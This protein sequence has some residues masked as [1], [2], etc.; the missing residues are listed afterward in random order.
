[1]PGLVHVLAP[2][3]V[4][5]A[6]RTDR[7]TAWPA[8]TP[9]VRRAL[10]EIEAAI[11]PLRVTVDLRCCASPSSGTQVHAVNLVAS[12]AARDELRLSVLVPRVVHESV[13]PHLDALPSSVIRH[14][15]GQ[16]ESSRHL[17]SFTGRT[18]FSR[19]RDHGRRHVGHPAG[20]HAS[21]HDPR[22]H[23]GVLRVARRV[24]P[25]HGADGA[26]LRRRRRGRVLLRARAGR[27]GAR[28]PRSID[29]RRPSCRRAR[30]TSATRATSRCR[31]RSVG[32]SH[33]RSPFVFVIGNSYFHKN[34]LFALR[35]TDELRRRTAGTA[36]SS[37]RA[38]TPATAPR[39][40]R[41]RELPARTTE[42]WRQIRRPSSRDRCRAPLAL[43]QR[44]AG[45]LS[46][47]STKASVSSR[48][49]LP[50]PGHRA[51]T[52]AGARL[53]SSFRPRERFSTSATSPRR[54]VGSTTCSRATRPGSDR[55]GHPSR[56]Q[57]LDV[58]ARGGLV[59]RH[60]PPS[61]DPTG[62]LS[63][64]LDREVVVGT[65]AQMVSSPTERRM[66]TALRRSAALRMVATA[67]VAGAS[68]LRRALRRLRRH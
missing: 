2:A 57:R 67:V 41:E 5:R 26:D 35:V 22:S 29:Q 47:V 19:E 6:G 54:H 39:S 33:P 53:P 34:R 3:V 44:G 45:P 18:R 64:A 56:R 28:R 60:L 65:R 32:R 7:T 12:L 30:I 62:G 42:S 21:G 52:R 66:L 11:E 38:A 40:R 10:A 59:S 23:T 31:L 49:R 14:I 27:G 43:P 55:S 61:N 17:T 51:C 1:M 50:P 24:A 25:V 46:D 20:R 16:G 4:D 68:S 13:Q 36:S 63:L 58:E 37:L 15:E 8:L 9:A 48:S